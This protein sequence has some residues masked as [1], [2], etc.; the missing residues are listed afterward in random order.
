MH[1]EHVLVFCK[2]IEWRRLCGMRCTRTKH[3]FSFRLFLFSWIHFPVDPPWKTLHASILFLCWRVLGDK[4]VALS[5]A[6][7][8]VPSPSTSAQ[9][10]RAGDAPRRHPNRINS[11]KLL[12]DLPGAY[13]KF[14][15]DFYD[16]NVLLCRTR[17]M[18]TKILVDFLSASV[19]RTHVDGEGSPADKAG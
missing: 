17:G 5:H 12:P 11:Q 9:P 4:T 1:L 16:R 7:L 10:W 14:T 8:S 18:G 3:T 2:R 6:T 13:F 15:V 19:S